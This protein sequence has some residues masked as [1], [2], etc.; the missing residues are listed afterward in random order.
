MTL[1]GFCHT[2]IAL[3]LAVA[4]A[5]CGSDGGPPTAP[6]DNPG[7]TGTTI[8]IGSN[9]VVSPRELTVSVGS[10]VTF[11]NNHNAAHEMTSDPHPDHTQCPSLN[12]VG[13]LATGQSRTSGNLNTPGVCGYHDHINDTNNNLKGTIRIQ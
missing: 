11:V 1:R 10:R 3:T 5:A 7:G 4:F 13:H 12:D 2:A 8:T 6:S 9:G